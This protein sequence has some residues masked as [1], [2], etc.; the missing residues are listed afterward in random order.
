[1][2]QSFFLRYLK[3]LLTTHTPT[4]TYVKYTALHTVLE[5]M[6]NAQAEMDIT[7]KPKTDLCYSDHNLRPSGRSAIFFYGRLAR[8]GGHTQL[9][10]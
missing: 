2:V 1:M 10:L 7:C 3:I 8:R 4:Y 9:F 5:K 6:S